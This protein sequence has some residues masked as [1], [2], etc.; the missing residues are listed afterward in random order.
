MVVYA[1]GAEIDTSACALE[2]SCTLTSADS[3]WRPARGWDSAQSAAQISTEM[4]LCE[5]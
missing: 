2:L 5:S 1:I 3:S 4:H